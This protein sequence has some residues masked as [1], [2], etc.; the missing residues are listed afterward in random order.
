MDYLFLSLHVDLLNMMLCLII[1]R[2]LHKEKGKQITTRQYQGT[3]YR[4]V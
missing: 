1:S 3:A 4:G 2:N